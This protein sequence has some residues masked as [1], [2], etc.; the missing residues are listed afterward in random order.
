MAVPESKDELIN[1]I[2]S[3]F[4]LLIKKL[5]AIPPAVAFDP[6][7]EGHAKGSIMS[8]AQL[9]SY[10]IGWGELV[11]H[12][13]NEE[14]KGGILVFPAEGY[15]WNE[16]GCLAQK[17]YCD[18]ESIKDYETLLARLKDNKQ[19]LL[20]LIDRFSNNELYG[21]PWYGKWTR[22]RMIQFNTASPYRNASGRLAKSKKQLDV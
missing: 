1:V 18:Y 17:F 3:N 13:H 20:A 15:K 9:V 21:E 16:L 8:V 12:W 2:N 10:L 14:A 7:M 11:L 4:S 19:Q 22:G 6:I 5:E